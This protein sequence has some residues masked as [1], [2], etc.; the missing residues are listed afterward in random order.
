MKLIVRGG[1]RCIHI[2]INSMHMLHAKNL[3][4][5]EIKKLT[6]LKIKIYSTHMAVFFLASAVH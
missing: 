5:M 6:T 1:S 3:P 4:T 2:K